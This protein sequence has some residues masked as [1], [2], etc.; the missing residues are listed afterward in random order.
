M[1]WPVS[2]LALAQVT[3]NIN[4]AAIRIDRQEAPLAIKLVL[5]LLDNDKT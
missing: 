5:R 1:H 4:E 2:R 3:A